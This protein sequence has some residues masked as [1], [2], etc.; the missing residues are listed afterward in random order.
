MLIFGLFLADDP[1][2]PE[3]TIFRHG[4][5]ICEPWCWYIY[6]KWI[7]FMA[8]VGMIFMVLPCFYGKNL[9]CPHKTGWFFWQMLGF[10]F[11]HHGEPIWDRNC[12]Q[13]TSVICSR[14]WD[15]W[16]PSHPS[17]GGDGGT[18]GPRKLDHDGRPEKY[19]EISWYTLSSYVL[20]INYHDTSWFKPEYLRISQNPQLE[21]SWNIS[22]FQY[23]LL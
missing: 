8:N 11:Q 12:C 10:I 15:P 2:W 4:V 23:S 3:P 20:F 17:P 6:S 22:C 9:I 16:I 19:H 5:P 21:I 14:A 1:A 7:I 18:V 13:Q